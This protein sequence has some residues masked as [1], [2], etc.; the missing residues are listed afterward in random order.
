MKAYENRP[1]IGVVFAV[2]TVEAISFTKSQETNN[3]LTG[4]YLA[5]CVHANVKPK[6]KPTADRRDCG[7][8]ESNRKSEHFHHALSLVPKNSRHTNTSSSLISIQFDIRSAVFKNNLIFPGGKKNNNN[9]N[10]ET[11][12][13]IHTC[14]AF[15]K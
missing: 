9:S 3:D 1:P 13:I 8:K 7:L 6:P 2:K 15:G 14:N 11:E 5:K 12:T 4:I 10:I